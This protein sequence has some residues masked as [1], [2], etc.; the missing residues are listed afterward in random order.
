[1]HKEEL[2]DLYFSPNIVRVIK[3]RRMKLSGHMARLRDRRGA[4]RV[5]VRTPEGKR[6]LGMPRRRWKDCVV[7][8]LQ[9][10]EWGGIDWIY[11]AEDWHRWRALVNAV[12][13]LRFL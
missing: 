11:L 7:I 4:Y 5:L 9:E 3:S 6:S 12:M 8:D 10:A 2:Y 13:N 1:M